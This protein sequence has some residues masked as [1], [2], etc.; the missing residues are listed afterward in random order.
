MLHLQILSI[1]ESNE[2]LAKQPFEH[3]DPSLNLNSDPNLEKVSLGRSHSNNQIHMNGELEEER[4]KEISRCIGTSTHT[5]DE[6]L[7]MYVAMVQLDFFSELLIGAVNGANDGVIRAKKRTLELEMDLH[8]S[9][10]SSKGTEAKYVSK[11]DD[12]AVQIRILEA[13]LHDLT[14]E[15]DNLKGLFI[16]ES[17]QKGKLDA[18]NGALKE[19]INKL[20]EEVTYRTMVEWR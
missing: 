6:I 14:E 7:A 13:K 18:E 10:K 11:C 15:R 2:T 20:N 5:E 4:S 8:E 1:Y 17:T 9:N 12:L 19:K 3:S 16:E